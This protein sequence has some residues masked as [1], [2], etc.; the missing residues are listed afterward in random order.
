MRSLRLHARDGFALPAALLAMIVIGAI[1]TGGFYVSAQE[2]NV[3]VST[4]MGAQAMIVAEY[5]LQETLANLGTTQLSEV[6]TAQVVEVASGVVANGSRQ[7]GSY[8]VRAMGLG[9][10]VYLLES[11]GLV[12]RGQHT[13]VRRV[14]ALVRASRGDVPFE[15]AI[16]AIG[17]FE[18]TGQS[19]VDGNDFCSADIKPGVTVTNDSLVTSTGAGY[20]D[21][22]P[23]IREYPDLNVDTL[24]S[25]GDWSLDDLIA[26]ADIQYAG[27][28]ADPTVMRPAVTTDSQ[29]NQFCSPT[30][31]GP[32]ATGQH[33]NWGE[34][35]PPTNSDHVAACAGHYPIIHSA[36]NLRLTSGRGQGVLIVEGNLEVDGNFAFDGVVIVTGNLTMAGTGG[37]TGGSKINGTVIVHGQSYLD[38][39]A[40][41]D[42]VASG[43][44]LIQWDSCAVAN[45]LGSLRTR[46]LRARSWMSDAP[47]LP[48]PL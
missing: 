11:E 16:T 44:A 1:V 28:P 48:R 3:S 35:L 19:R 38:P 31:Y 26:M 13:A 24:R 9:G 15:G 4:D 21:G 6:G 34:P 47:A 32:Y 18:R 5:G 7:V 30:A 46:Q 27:T 36:G 39:D 25:F 10:L 22:S 45:A 12:E 41:G 43:N 40:E 8:E 29:G 33:H 20:I 23:R 37:Q 2:H 14:S 17:S 42:H